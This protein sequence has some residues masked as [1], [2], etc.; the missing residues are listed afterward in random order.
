MSLPVDTLR[1]WRKD[2]VAF[3]RECFGVEPDAWQI[4]VL[5]LLVD[6]SVKRISMQA[7]VGPGKSA[8]LA[9]IAWW[10]MTC[11]GEVGKHPK[12]AAVAVTGDNLRDNLW[13]EISKWQQRSEYLM[14]AFQWTKERIFSKDHPTTW[15]I[16]ARSFSQKANPD[17]QGRT[18]SGLHSEYVLILCD[19]SG[20]I[21]PPVIK[22]AEQALSGCTWGKIVQA[23]NPTSQQ[24]ILYQAAT[25]WRHL[26]K[27]ICITGD[28]DDPKRSP[29]I[30][31]EW[32]REQI[33]AYGRDHPWVM[34]SILGKFPPTSV[35]SLL[36]IEE[37]QESMRRSYN[38][39]QV[40]Y[41]QKRIG[42][43]AARFG[44]DPWVFFKRQG[45]QSYTPKVLRNPL[46]HE[47]AAFMAADR[48]N[49]NWDMA[50]FDDTGGYSAGAIDCCRQV[51]LPVTGVN[52]A[53][54]SP[55]PRYFNMRSYM[56][57][58]MAEWVKKGGALPAN[59]D[60]IVPELT[61]PTFT[62]VDGK[63]RV[64]EKEFV[65]K[66]LKR[67]PNHGDAL[68]NTFCIPDIP[69]SQIQV[70]GMM[71]EWQKDQGK[72]KSDWNPFK[73]IQDSERRGELDGVR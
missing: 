51:G 3:V 57:M 71:V 19:E 42:V 46:T 54:R 28:P 29:R 66:R 20:E 34:S 52:Y 7:C 17:E 21:P 12:G 25:V 18:M 23:G 45:L 50:F 22:V 44:D 70:D 43:D 10:F 32:A 33:K 61:V 11:C 27:V 37:V 53:S 59:C 38:D 15:F 39:E 14:E 16:S 9:W 1:R 49:W 2:P 68:A 64:E 56:W 72:V 4:E 60:E 47:V 24:G 6:K 8:L 48:P 58:K 40:R 31:I 41:T 26:W 55:D 62:Y 36:S 5:L 30:D 69:A 63:F 67:S 13:A 73:E 65:K 35:N